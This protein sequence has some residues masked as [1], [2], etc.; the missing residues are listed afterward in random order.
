MKFLCIY[1]VKREGKMN[2]ILS[3]SRNS[4]AFV[5]SRLDYCNS[6]FICVSKYQLDKLQRIQNS[7]ATVYSHRRCYDSISP[8]LK[9]LHWLPIKARIDYKTA[10]LTHK[11]LHCEAPAYLHNQVTL[12]R[13]YHC[14]NRILRSTSN[15]NVVV[16]RHCTT[17]YGNGLFSHSAPRVWNSLPVKIRTKL[18]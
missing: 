3:K 18:P 2:L 11:I 10:V 16:T 6:L 17:R 4:Q 14:R 9:E 7:A 13:T 8:V 1:V 15:F 12:A 5:S